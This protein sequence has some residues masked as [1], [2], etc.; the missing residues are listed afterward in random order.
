MEDEDLFKPLS[1][2]PAPRAGRDMTEAEARGYADRS[3]ENALRKRAA[4]KRDELR[5]RHGQ[6]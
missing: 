1:A 5:A 4:L 6:R 2:K 3:L